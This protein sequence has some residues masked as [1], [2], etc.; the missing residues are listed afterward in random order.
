ELRAARDLAPDDGAIR[1]E[2]GVAALLARRG[3]EGLH[4]LEEALSRIDESWLRGLYALA[5]LEGGRPEEGA[6]HLFRAA[7]ERP[8]DVELQLLGALAFAEQGWEDEAWNAVARAEAAAEA[9]DRDL[10]REVEEAVEAG[11]EEAGA[12]LRE[13][14]GPSL[15]RDRLSQRG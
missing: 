7:Q 2:L 6:E 13:Q 3:E 8:E 14:L 9:M 5:L 12:F 11:P 15:L 10:I 4:E 1:A